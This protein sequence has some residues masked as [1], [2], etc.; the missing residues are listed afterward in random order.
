MNEILGSVAVLR[1]LA[2]I[3][4]LDGSLGAFTWLNPRVREQAAEGLSIDDPGRLLQ[5]VPVA[6]KELFDVAGA[7]RTGG[8]RVLDGSQAEHDSP[9]VRAIR[10]QG[11]L[12]L[13]LT[14]SHE[15]AWG[16]TTQHETRGGTGHPMAPSRIPGGSSG[17]SAVAV[18]TGMARLA[19]GTDTGGSTRIPAAFCGVIGFKPT[20]G[21]VPL[22]GCMPL[23]PTLDTVG[24]IA[25]AVGDIKLM[26]QGLAGQEI[27]ATVNWDAMNIGIPAGVSKSLEPRTAPVRAGAR[28][29]ARRGATIHEV[30]MPPEDHV[31]SVFA[32][33]Q[34]REA[35]VIHRDVLGSYPARSELYG[36]DVRERLATAALQRDEEYEWAVTA[37]EE[38]RKEMSGILGDLD[39]I[40][41]PIA[42]IT[43]PVRTN[44][45]FVSV[46]AMTLRKA[47]MGDTVLQNLCGLPALSL[48]SG[49]TPEGFPAAVQVT[50]GFHRDGLC[51]AVA[52]GLSEGRPRVRKPEPFREDS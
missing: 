13:G 46:G 32:H 39:A 29:L 50:S 1:C 17:G 45:D 2:A 23:A 22:V 19:L 44:P 12:V 18:A 9:C 24:L 25:N 47:V 4:D 5:G 49:V 34:M 27:D 38:L 15:F 14:R 7:P 16:I 20:W 42:S 37:R 3:A 33:V 36:R 43:P 51:V 26:F 11:G 52:E 8:S 40:L 10:E 31:L 21:L 30:E 35:L 6:V 48:P 28:V 41:S